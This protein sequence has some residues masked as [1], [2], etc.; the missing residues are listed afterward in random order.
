L[1][2]ASEAFTRRASPGEQA[3][4]AG[5]GSGGWRPGNRLR[6]NGDSTLLFYS[7]ATDDGIDSGADIAPLPTAF[8]ARQATIVEV[9]TETD[10]GAFYTPN[11]AQPGFDPRFTPTY[12]FV[13]DGTAQ[14]TPEPGTLALTG[15]GM[16]GLA[17]WLRRRKKAGG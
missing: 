17:G 4:S 3:K 14:A 8:Y 2:K 9:G 10:N 5:A 6:F 7:L 15:L 16:L 13:S 12:H 11:D 1:D